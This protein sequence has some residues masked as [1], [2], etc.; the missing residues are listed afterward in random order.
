MNMKRFLTV[1][2][3]LIMVFAFVGCGDDEADTFADADL[4]VGYIYIGSVNDGG[5]T[6]SMYEG[7]L[8]SEEHFAGAMA[9]KYRENVSEDTQEVKNT[10]LSL[11]DEGCNVIIACSYG[12]GDAM[13]ELSGEY[14]DVTFLHFSGSMKNDTNFDNW[15]GS[16][17]QAR[18]L[19]GMAAA[20]VTES[21]ILGYV[22]AHPFTEV[23]IGI[24]AFT[25]GAQAVNPDVEVKVVYIGTWGDA[26]KE[27]NGAEELLNEGADVISY[28]ADSTASQLAAAE[29]DAWA[30]GWNFPKNDMGA[31]GKYLTAAYWN[32]A[33]YFN[34]ALQ[35]V[36]DGTFVP[37]S[38]YGTMADGLIAIDEINDA[39]PADVQEAIADTKAKMEAGEFEVFTGPIYYK[40]GSVLCEEGE[41]L[42]R[43]GIWSINS[44]I[45]GVSASSTN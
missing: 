8:A 41:F 39:V 42:D 31:D 16:M 24:N 27:K 3:A 25:L 28:H 26:E 4:R 13:N 29:R 15:F 21:N 5:F 19:T 2:L 7:A 9:F 18:Y 35:N 12:F 37:E 20:S 45:K 40:D 38:Y 14:E 44:E 43:A 17:E 34:Y 33:V 23:Q 22:A 32:P 30:I 6:Q 10:A 11:I 1:L 36:L